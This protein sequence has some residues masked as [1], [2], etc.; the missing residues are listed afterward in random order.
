[1][2]VDVHRHFEGGMTQPLLRG[3]DVDVALV[4]ALM[5]RYQRD[6]ATDSYHFNML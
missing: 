3:L 4:K 2:R 6:K 5:E 1:V